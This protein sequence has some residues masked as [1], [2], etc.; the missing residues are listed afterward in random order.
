MIV[1]RL[2]LDNVFAF[3]DFEIMLSYPKKIVGSTIEAEFLSGRTNFRYKKLI[4][5]MGANASGKTT[6]G[7]AFMA[8]FNSINNKNLLPVIKNINDPTKK[9]SFTIEFVAKTKRL[10][11]VEAVISPPGTPESY[12][13]KDMR[14]SV[15]SVPISLADSYEMCATKLDKLG[16]DNVPYHKALESIENFGWL[17][18]YPSIEEKI[19][20][21]QELDKHDLLKILDIVL[22]ALDPSIQ[23]IIKARDIKNSYVIKLGNHEVIIQDGNVLNGEIL[24]SGTRSGIGI[25]S[26][27]AAIMAKQNGFYYCDEKFSYIHSDME[28]EALAKMVEKLGEDGQLFFTTHNTDILDMSF[29]KHSYCFL[30]KE[31][32][33]D[34]CT[35]RCINA[36]D[37]LK[38]NTDSLKCAVENDLFST[39]PDVS[40][41]AAL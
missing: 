36:D 38:R 41:I 17:F 19:P 18:T 11:R 9:A 16:A 25:A 7:K 24:S 30:K 6:L 3:N 22:S 39:A 21:F 4:I 23:G 15:K 12:E 10:Y 27:L 37:F 33:G 13:E 2:K 14:V 31:Q 1:M 35:I 28:R 34:T 8:I 32:I 29:P 5:L 26:M 20:T 40:R